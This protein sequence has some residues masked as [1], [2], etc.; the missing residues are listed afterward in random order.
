MHIALILLYFVL[1]LANALQIQL[2]S[3]IFTLA[4]NTEHKKVTKIYISIVKLLKKLLFL[5]M[6]VQCYVAG[7]EN[8]VFAEIIQLMCLFAFVLI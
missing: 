3:Y 4:V 5:C 2:V 1:L 6:Y 8:L 7:S